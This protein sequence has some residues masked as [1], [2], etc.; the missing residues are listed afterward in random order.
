MQQTPSDS[1]QDHASITA[2]LIK[3]HGPIISG[4]Q[5][6]RAMGFPSAKAF[7]Q[8]RRRGSLGISTFTIAGRRGTFALTAD[9]G[10]WFEVV[11][12]KPVG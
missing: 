5:L 3:D 9:L 1:P 8:A 2:K 10:K 7:S 4:A 11:T 12:A 6:Y